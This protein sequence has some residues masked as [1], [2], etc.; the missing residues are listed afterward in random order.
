M[1][2]NN[3]AR[4]A[5]FGIH[6]GLAQPG[7]EASPHPSTTPTIPRRDSY[8]DCQTTTSLSASATVPSQLSRP[9]P[10]PAPAIASPASPLPATAK[11]AGQARIPTPTMVKW[12]CPHLALFCWHLSPWLPGPLNIRDHGA[13][14]RPR[15]WR[16]TVPPSDTTACT[17]VGSSSPDVPQSLGDPTTCTAAHQVLQCMGE[18]DSHSPILTL[19]KKVTATA[20]APATMSASHST[21]SHASPKGSKSNSGVTVKPPLHIDIPSDNTHGSASGL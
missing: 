11:V 18:G 10:G 1:G 6:L 7:T 4:N 17:P 20:T 19:K 2:T 9:L 14:Y 3:M 8:G 5:F 12:P 21:S 15:P 16:Q 13:P